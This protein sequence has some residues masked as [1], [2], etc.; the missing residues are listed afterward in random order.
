MYP[1][2]LRAERRNNN[3]RTARERQAGRCGRR[4]RCLL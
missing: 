2:F 3:R 1:T 4:S